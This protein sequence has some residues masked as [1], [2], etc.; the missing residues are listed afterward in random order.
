MW[1]NLDISALY[2]RVKGFS[3][4]IMMSSSMY[5]FYVDVLSTEDIWHYVIPNL[6][7]ESSLFITL[8]TYWQHLAEF[9]KWTLLFKLA[10]T[11][12]PFKR[13][14]IMHRA[15]H[16]RHHYQDTVTYSNW[17]G[18]FIHCHFARLHQKGEF[19]SF[20]H[21]NYWLNI[22]GVWTLHL[23]LCFAPNDK[24]INKTNIWQSNWQRK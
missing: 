9:W 1:I 18:Y 10:F 14:Y 23:F 20:N 6:D 7:F 8:L 16:C 11:F 21:N 5:G 12:S 17:T 24:L 19:A 15:Q 4:C 22:F 3:G 13:S 2:P